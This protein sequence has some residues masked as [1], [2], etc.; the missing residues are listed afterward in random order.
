LE[1]LSNGNRLFLS[2]FLSLQQQETRPYINI[3]GFPLGFCDH[4]SYTLES[5]QNPYSFLKSTE[6]LL[7]KKAFECNKELDLQKN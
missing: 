2:F 1:Q 7:P 4:H 6:L 3:S 5:D